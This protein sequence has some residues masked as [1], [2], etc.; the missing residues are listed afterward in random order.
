ML[1]VV[2]CRAACAQQPAALPAGPVPISHPP[3]TAAPSPS[4][5]QH[6]ATPPPAPKRAAPD[7]TP[8]PPTL[9]P[10]ATQGES[11]V[12]TRAVASPVVPNAWTRLITPVAPCA[13]PPA[14][15]GNLDDHCWRA[16]THA[17]GFYPLST[18]FP[19]A[20]ADQT[21]VW[22]CADKTHL[23]IAFRCLDSQAAHLVASATQRGASLDN[24]DFVGVDIDSQNSRRN[25]STFLVNPR[26]IQNENLEGG[27]ADNITWAGDWKAAASRR[28][29]GWVCEMSIPFALLRYPRGANAF[30]I[31]FFRHRSAG[32]TY[33]NWPY[34][35]PAGSSSSGEG[36]YMHL[37]TGIAPPFLT[38]RPVFLP[39]TLA[40]AGSLNAVREGLD[41]KYPLTTTLTGVASLFPDFQTI[42]QDVTTINFSYTEKLL[43]D[44]RPFFAEG[45]GFFP[46][47]D[48][49]YSRRIGAVDGG[50]KVVGKQGDTT[51]G[52]L[53]T[54]TRG[55]NA[56]NDTVLNLQKDIGLFSYLALNTVTDSQK[57]LPANQVGKIEGKYGW[58][59]G[60]T[61]YFVLANHAPSY[62]QGHAVGA[63]DFYQ[64]SYR[65]DNGHVRVEADYSDIGP[66]F[67][68]D[69]GFVPETD[70]RGA[71]TTIQQSNHF[72]RGT[73]QDYNAGVYLEHY[74]HHTGGF[75]HSDIGPFV[76]VGTRSGLSYNL[77]YDQ[78][79]R[80]LF[81]DHVG[82]AAFG[83]ATHTLYQQG[84]LSDD[85]GHQEGQ[86]YNFLAFSQG[87]LVTRPFSVQ[88]NYNRL[89]LGAQ[90][91]TQA[92]ATGTYRL[93][94]TQ[95]V[96][97][98]IVSQTGVDQGTG[99]GTNV[100]FSFGQQVRAGT[101]V[102]L[103]FGDP[104]SPKTRGL[105]TLKVVRPF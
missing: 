27:T 82:H 7:V 50:L 24:D 78:S 58:A 103:L 75:F 22:L 56:Q 4:A 94:A 76:Y 28:A 51:V 52:L 31:D 102:F 53:A 93:N 47:R 17:A 38:P 86:G 20:P 3:G 100:Y 90:T 92:I 66:A 5:P 13:A 101:D 57:G 104:N 48:L 67:T 70:L 89:K 33:Q 21:E 16:A 84:S 11:T 72:D 55:A 12:F 6:A 37:F 8:T 45:A 41:I 42:E 68:S 32:N 65:P 63:S 2:L 87:V 29:D 14:I 97:G 36:A 88:L 96:G 34:L 99:L 98:R 10:T 35:P 81:H 54:D 19:I 80:D 73:V 25:F 71:S 15:D 43:T 23:Y 95:T 61:R 62:V 40:S 105:V 77:G 59:N 64:F 60:P 83:W 39:Y 30:G 69:L 49:F 1:M 85:F 44:R 79:R 26:G 91:S 46:Y 74:D 18:V 9:G